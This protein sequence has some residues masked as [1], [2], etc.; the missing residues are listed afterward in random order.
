MISSAEDLLDWTNLKEKTPANV[1]VHPW[2]IDPEQPRVQRLRW[3]S[4]WRHY[5]NLRS[6]EKKI[7][8]LLSSF[9]FA[10]LA[11]VIGE[12]GETRTLRLD[13]LDRGPTDLASKTPASPAD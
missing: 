5:V 1:Y 6:T 3:P 12:L 4:R 7:R 9:E 11:R 8:N 2:E 13:E 10:P